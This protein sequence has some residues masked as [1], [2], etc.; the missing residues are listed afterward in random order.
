MH[1]RLSERARQ[2]MRQAGQE[3]GR[4]NHEYLGTEH[5][6]LGLID[7]P[8]GVT[9][10][11]LANLNT[12]PA[13][14]RHGIEAVLFARREPVSTD[15]APL[16]PLAS[17][18]LEYAQQEAGSLNRQQV[19]P[20]HLLLGLMREPECK[21]AQLLARLGLKLEAVRAEVAQLAGGAS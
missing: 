8:G 14:I 4:L 15:E 10:Q 20:E 17:R 11:V 19:E 5:V 2:V 1:Q 12:D 3:A 13:K 7:E 9:A 21:P 16:S 18:V 6:L